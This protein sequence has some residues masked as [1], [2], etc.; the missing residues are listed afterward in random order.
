MGTRRELDLGTQWTRN[1]AGRYCLG[2]GYPLTLTLASEEKEDD[3]RITG[4]ATAN[5]RTRDLG[6]LPLV[7]SEHACPQAHMCYGDTDGG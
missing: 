4:P 2:L 5:F 7:I 6:L 1:A 3:Y